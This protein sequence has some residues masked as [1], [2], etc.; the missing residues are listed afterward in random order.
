MH[1]LVM[2]QVFQLTV[3]SE[4]DAY[5]LQHKV[6]NSYQREI[7]IILQRVLD[8]ICTDD[9]VIVIDRLEIDLGEINM[10]AM[11]DDSW[12]IGLEEALREGLSELVAEKNMK[13][14]AEAS[15][16]RRP[17]RS[18]VFGQWLFSMK[19]GYLPWNAGEVDDSW[20]LQVLEAVA[21]D[22]VIASELRQALAAEP[23]VVERIVQQHAATFL[24]PL[25]EALTA[26]GQQQLAT[27]PEEMLAVV[28]ALDKSAVITKREIERV[29]WKKVLLLVAAP[30]GS[31]SASAGLST[32]EILRGL[33]PVFFTPAQRMWV[34]RQAPVLETSL[35]V[36]WPV[37][38]VGD[39]SV[40]QRVE[41]LVLRSLEMD[42]VTP[43]I[44][45]EVSG[46][47]E[48]QGREISVGQADGVEEGDSKRDDKNIPAEKKSDVVNNTRESIENKATDEHAP[49]KEQG[50]S[51]A[52]GVYQDGVMMIDKPGK[53]GT[54]PV[55][56]PGKKADEPVKRKSTSIEEET[57]KEGPVAADDVRLEKMKVRKTAV[58]VIGGEEIFVHHAGV[59]LLH[60]FLNAFF[61]ILGLVAEGKFLSTACHTRALYLIHF[62]ATGAADPHEHD[63]LIAK[64]LCGYP[65]EE[66]V[67]VMVELS[68][69]EMEEAGN[70][71]SAAIASWSILKSTSAAGLREGFLQRSGKLQVKGNDLLLLVENSSIDM[72]LDHLPWNLSI[73]KLPWM[74]NILRTEW[75]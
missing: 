5:Y 28:R 70:L 9:Q 74:E 41:P 53:E 44:G 13:E 45:I 12:I 66:P 54:I 4:K 63:L 3:D 43:S 17:G 60:P 34:A 27:V 20:Y 55:D 15:I 8:D 40:I 69:S 30:A 73:I 49:V 57:P 38:T 22:H 21:T 42:N 24:V 64:I 32:I 48:I 33:A 14:N 61:K 65:L 59:V 56:D 39:L 11:R 10:R 6:S 75:R 37:F 62:L 18:G 35:P 72:L 7:L 47:R 1:H 31:T 2:R 19:R 51:S 23:I 36:L 50:L 26:K 71:L 16:Q 58:E 68:D 25:T 52:E 67:D 46:S 29:F